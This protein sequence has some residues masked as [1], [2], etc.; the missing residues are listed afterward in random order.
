MCLALYIG[1]END[2][3]EIELRKIPKEIFKLS[4][5]PAVAQRFRVSALDAKQ[6]VVRC[7][8]SVPFVYFAGSYE[9]CSCGFNYGRG[10]FTEYAN[11][12]DHLLAAQESVAELVRYIRDHQV[13]ELYAC[14]FN[15]ESLPNETIRIVSIEDLASQTFVFKQR[16]LIKLTMPPNYAL[17]PTSPDGLAA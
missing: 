17:E 7:H 4:E 6:H 13:K 3:P 8:F 16:E 1:S 12:K 15:D 2:L 11:D 5:W 14:S 9:G 10:E